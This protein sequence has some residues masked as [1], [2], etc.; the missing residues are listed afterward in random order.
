MICRAPACYTAEVPVLMERAARLIQS[1]KTSRELFSEEDLLRAI[2]P[3][4]VGRVIASHTCGLRLV[5]TTLVVEVEDAVWQA[6]LF[7]LRSQILNRLRQIG[8]QSSIDDIEFRVAIPRRQPQR[9]PGPRPRA[10]ESAG[11]D[12]ADRIADPVLRKV[13]LLSRKRASV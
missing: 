4:A 13:Y 8:G 7:A 12:E 3:Q 11:N 9:E 5:R 10:L 6:Q 1:H 2:W